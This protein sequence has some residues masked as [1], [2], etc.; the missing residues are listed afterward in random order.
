MR[1]SGSL[2]AWWQPE[3][4]S[5]PPMLRDH[6]LACYLVQ[7]AFSHP[8]MYVGESSGTHTL[9]AIFLHW[10]RYES[11]VSCTSSVGAEDNATC[12]HVELEQMAHQSKCDI[13][14]QVTEQ[15]FLAAIHTPSFSLYLY[16]WQLQDFFWQLRWELSCKL[17]SLLQHT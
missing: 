14:Q 16:A 8:G 1:L 3:I 10:S 11:I 12:R 9:F 4:C 7:R 5:P 13:G 17:N 15:L 2:N 6:L